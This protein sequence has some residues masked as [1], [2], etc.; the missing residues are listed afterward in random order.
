M[1]Y[2]AKMLT[3]GRVH[4][5]EEA[6]YSFLHLDNSEEAELIIVNDYPHQTLVFDHPRVKIVNSPELFPSIGHKDT[7][8]H[9]LCQ[10]DI[11]LVF[12]DDDI[13]LPNH[14]LNIDKYLKDNDLLHWG[15][16]VYYNESLDGTYRDKPSLQFTGLGN[17]G[18]VYTHSAYNE[19]GKSPLMNEAGDK[20]LVEKLTNLRGKV[21]HAKPDNRDVSWFYRWSTPMNNGVGNYHQSGLGDPVEGRENAMI[22]N[23]NYLEGLRKLKKLPVGTIKLEPKWKHNY[24]RLLMEKFIQ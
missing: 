19:I 16:G 22:R 21:V 20:Y 12:D 8:A 24:I 15:N 9:D 5:L 2:S 6:L 13:A 4:L 14:L 7:F 11:I 1:K 18:I 17:S 23:F 10:G 3:A